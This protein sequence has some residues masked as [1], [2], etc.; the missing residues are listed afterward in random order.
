[1]PQGIRHFFITHLNDNDAGGT[2][3]YG[4]RVNSLYQRFYKKNPFHALHDCS[5]DGEIDPNESN[6]RKVICNNKAPLLKVVKS[7][8][9]HDDG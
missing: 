7:L 4:S 3:M 8:W 9:Y 1:M 5:N 2:A 6:K